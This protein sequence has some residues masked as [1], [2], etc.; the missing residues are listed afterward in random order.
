MTLHPIAHPRRFA[1]LCGAAAVGLGMSFMAAGGAPA[2]YLAMNGA[3]LL[4]GLLA[5]GVIVEARRLISLPANLVS[6]VLAALLLAVSIWGVSADGVTRWISLGGLVL[7][8]S[9]VLVPILVLGLV[10]SRDGLSILAVTIAAV[11]LALQ[12]DR[13]MAAALAAG[14]VPIAWAGRG[15]RELG[16]L[17][18]ALIGLAITMI[19]PDPSPAMPFV[20]Q[21]LFTSFSVHPLAGLAVWCGAALLLV[22]AIAGLAGDRDQRLAWSAF[23]AIWL[24]VIIAAALGNYP[25][26]L[27]GYG[28]S[29][30]LG[31][32]LS[33]IALPPRNIAKGLAPAEETGG[34][35]PDGA[36]TFR[37]EL[38]GKRPRARRRRAAIDPFLPSSRNSLTG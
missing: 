13:A 2:A 17:A 12:P 37:V 31:Y 33:I 11:A 6:I 22:P 32:M 5:L 29:A 14:L 30:I 16:A 7:Q 27:V 38:A 1:A 10:R 28:G 34:F 8:P 35:D 24:T 18:V 19:R 15:R 25:T 23:G 20:D 9:L 3:A 26:P 36:G 21:I 4:I